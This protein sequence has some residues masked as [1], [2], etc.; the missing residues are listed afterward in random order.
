[1]NKIKEL[2][3]EAKEE[4]IKEISKFLLDNCKALDKVILVYEK[5]YSSNTAHTRM[6]GVEYVGLLEVVKLSGFETWND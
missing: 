2:N 1:M 5:N 4:K 3:F 6:S